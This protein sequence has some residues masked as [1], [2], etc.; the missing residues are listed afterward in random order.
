MNAESIIESLSLSPHPEGGYYSET[1]RSDELYSGEQLPERY[2]GDRNHGTA[3]Y[4]LLCGTQFSRMHLLQSDEIFHF[5]LGTPVEMLL[6]EPSGKSRVC[7]LGSDL[8]KGQSPQQLVP[9]GVWQGARLKNPEAD[10]FA[11]L[12]CTVSPGFDFSDFHLSEAANLIEKFPD[13]ED[14]IRALCP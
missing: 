2:S 7:T 9:R 1:Y 13:R 5:Y 10:S 14:L 4:Y 6:L 3:I 11:L 12:G 8:S